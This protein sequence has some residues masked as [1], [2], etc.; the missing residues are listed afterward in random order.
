MVDLGTTLQLNAGT[1]ELIKNLQ[2]SR[3]GF[4]ENQGSDADGNVY[5]QEIFTDRK[6]KCYS[7][8]KYTGKTGQIWFLRI[9]PP[10]FEINDQHIA[11]T[12]PYVIYNTSRRDW[13]DYFERVLPKLAIHPP[14]LAHNE[15]LKYGL[16]PNYWNEY[17]FQAYA[18]HLENA[19]YLA[20]I[21][22]K[23]E[24]LPHFD[25]SSSIDINLSQI[26]GKEDKKKA[27]KKF[28]KKQKKRG[29]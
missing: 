12:T 9:A 7:S 2:S 18:N 28:T 26:P 11:I 14:L 15:L 29:K 16:I 22:D 1:I 5:L 17:V 19:I 4:Y 6:Y 3:M 13:E 20:G 8:S 27:I 23:P 10:P 24:S 25:P 21:P